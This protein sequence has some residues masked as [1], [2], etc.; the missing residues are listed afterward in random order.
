MR[1]GRIVQLAIAVVVAGAIYGDRGALIAL[2]VGLA[3]VLLSQLYLLPAPRREALVADGEIDRT[4]GFPTYTALYAG[5]VVASASERSADLALVPGLRRI[6][7]AQVE[8]AG[9]PSVRTRLG[10]R[11][12]SLLD[13][14]REISDNSSTGGLS[15]RELEDLFARL[16][17]HPG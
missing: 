15:A 1:V 7:A 10:E 13:P 11:W 12:W 6:V 5:I 17:A 14:A 16:E 3:L 9:V 8:E 4:S 2:V